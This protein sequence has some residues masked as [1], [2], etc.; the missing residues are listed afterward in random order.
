MAEH[1][2]DYLGQCLKKNIC[3]TCQ[4]TIA[5]KFGSGKT[6]DG[7]FCSL[8]C[9]TEWNKELLIRQ[10]QDRVQKSKTDE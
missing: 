6:K 9:F 8:D 3:P 2:E 4:Q 1:E 7:V 10:H 5:E